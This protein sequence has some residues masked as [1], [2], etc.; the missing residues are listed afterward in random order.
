VRR[1]AFQFYPE[2]WT[3][4]GKLNRCSWAARGAWAHVLCLFHESDEYGVLR[5]PLVDIAQASSGCPIKLLRELVSKDVLKGSDTSNAAYVYTPRHAG[6]DGAPVTLLP[7]GEGPC[8]YSSRMVRDEYIRGKRGAGTRYGDPPNTTPEPSPKGGIGEGSGD[9][10]LV[11]VSDSRN[12][13]V[14]TTY[15]G[16]LPA[17]WFKTAQGIEAAG[18]TLGIPAKRGET[19]TAYKGRLFAAIAA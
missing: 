12:I 1:P 10:P 14:D 13:G 4:N 18:K 2:R 6:Q 19:L 8:W 9:G 17:D 16:G 5:W 7:A 3:S 11:L 15:S